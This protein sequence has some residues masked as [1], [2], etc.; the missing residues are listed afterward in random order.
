M[1]NILKTLKNELESLKIPYVY[2]KWESDVILP[3]FVGELDEIPTDDEDGKSEYSFT[4]TGED[5]ETYSNL[6]TYAEKLK[7]EYKQSKKIKLDG[8]YIVVSYE[9]TQTIP[10]DL[11][12]VKRIQIKFTIYL[13]E[14]E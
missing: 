4:L 14:E 6:Y 12:S 5:V 8:G 10:I 13:W 1:I 11:P 7:K 2:D 9:N 3:F